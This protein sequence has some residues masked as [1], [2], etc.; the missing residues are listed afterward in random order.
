[1]A[2]R[3]KQRDGTRIPTNCALL[4]MLLWALL[5]VPLVFDVLLPTSWWKTYSK[6]INKMLD[7]TFMPGRPIFMILVLTVPPTFVAAIVGGCGESQRFP[8][9]CL[10]CTSSSFTTDMKALSVLLFVHLAWV[11]AR[12]ER[13]KDW[14]VTLGLL[15]MINM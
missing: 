15:A 14:K 11:F 13:E 10:P 3:S 1:M 9:P 5:L 8:M 12:V 7:S 4:P 2:P 6:I